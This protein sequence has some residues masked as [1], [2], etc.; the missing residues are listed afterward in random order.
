M[1]RR[2]TQ[3][4]RCQNTLRSQQNASLCLLASLLVIF[5]VSGCAGSVTA[6]KPASAPQLAI[7]PSSITF[8]NVIVGQK[9]TQTVQISNTGNANLDVSAITLTGAG[10]SLGPISAPMQ[11]APGASQSFTV[12][13]SPTAV[14]NSAKATISIAS[15]DP[16]SPLSVSVQ[17]TSIK[18]SA[19][20]QIL[21]GSFTFP[22]IAVQS[23][24]SHDIQLSNNGNQAITISS[25]SVTGSA[26][27]STGL[28]AGTV[29][30]PNQGIHFSVTFHPMAAGNATGTF[31]ITGGSSVSPI[32]ASLQ[33][34]ATAASTPASQHSVTLSWNDSGSGIAGY[35]IYRGTSSGGPY[36]GITSSLI[37]IT[38][39]IDSSVTSGGKYYYVATAVD[40]SGNESA[41]SNEASAT[42]PNP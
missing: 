42:I 22:S 19:S 5:L 41:F 33:G 17:G 30:Y 32:I 12:S 40:N 36:V 9:N 2:L 20:W 1:M 37:S 16:A 34:T 38:S 31:Q 35:R 13:F 21:S 23:S 15:N 18:A 10:F 8:Q 3:L 39:Y 28:N 26:F 11:I 27:S 29:I 14:T 25:V 7:T 4:F 6:D 24:L